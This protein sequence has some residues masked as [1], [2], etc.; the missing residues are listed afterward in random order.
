MHPVLPTGTH[1]GARSTQTDL[2]TEGGAV[3]STLT[4]EKE[5]TML[6]LPPPPPAAAAAGITE[7]PTRVRDSGGA[8][9]SR[10]ERTRVSWDSRAMCAA[11]TGKRKPTDRKTI[12][13]GRW[14][15]MG[16][17]LQSH[18]LTTSEAIGFKNRL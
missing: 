3:K 6:L 1:M 7:H 15:E 14:M 18:A 16:V 4:A 13:A 10:T 17:A 9:G 5:Q 11:S 2:S 12:G 8:L